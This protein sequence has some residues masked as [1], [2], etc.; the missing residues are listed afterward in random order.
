MVL[1]TTKTFLL[2][3][4]CPGVLRFGSVGDVPPAA[5][6]Q[7]H[8]TRTKFVKKIPGFVINKTYTK[9]FFSW[10]MWLMYRDFLYRSDPF[11]RDI[12]K[13]F[14]MWV[15]PDKHEVVYEKLVRFNSQHLIV[16]LQLLTS[17]VTTARQIISVHKITHEASQNYRFIIYWFSHF[18]Y[19]N[20]TSMGLTEMKLWF[21]S[22][23]EQFLLY[24]LDTLS[25]VALFFENIHTKARIHERGLKLSQA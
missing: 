3:V 8:K 20:F 19:S 2:L 24:P 23:L 21:L 4:T 15:P 22:S 12:L 18:I 10:K 7:F 14:N 5:Q 9:G 16:I 1:Q 11:L 6:D 13:C 17:K 25:E